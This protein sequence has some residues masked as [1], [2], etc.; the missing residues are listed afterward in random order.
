MFRNSID[1]GSLI[2]CKVEFRVNG[3]NGRAILWD[4][5]TSI[6]I[7]CA[8]SNGEMVSLHRPSAA[9]DYNRENS[10]R[11]PD[12]DITSRGGGRSVR[13]LLPLV[14]IKKTRRT[15]EEAF[16]KRGSETFARIGWTHAML[17]LPDPESVDPARMVLA[18]PGQSE[19]E[20]CH[21]GA[22]H[23]D[24]VARREDSRRRPNLTPTLR[25]AVTACFK[26]D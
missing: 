10:L 7:Y 3:G 24:T 13:W 21:S 1:C 9:P 4:L 26:R 2:C 16:T 14:S 22:N 19:T 20:G 17:V 25:V 8:T 12:F 23:K 11:I 6:S 15:S 5:Y 18:Q